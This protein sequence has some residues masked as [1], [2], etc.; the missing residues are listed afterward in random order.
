MKTCSR[1]GHDNLE[2]LVYCTKCSQPLGDEPTM[3]LSTRQIADIESGLTSKQNWGTARFAETASFFLHVRGASTPM[4]VE[5]RAETVLGRADAKT[6]FVP[7]L[8]FTEYGAEANGV[9][10]QHAVLVRMGDTL[11]LVDK[12]SANGTYLNGQRLAP[13]Q[14]RTFAASRSS[15][16]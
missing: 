5:P 12:G 3:R 6:G 10:R 14:P 16:R 8:D 4:V 1:C 11:T 13:D 15:A 9:S 2:G 7:D